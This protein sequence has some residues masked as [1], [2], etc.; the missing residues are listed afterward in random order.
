MVQEPGSLNA[1]EKQF[2]PRRAHE[3]SRKGCAR[4][5]QQRKKCDEVKPRCTRCAVRNY[6]CQYLHSPLESKAAEERKTFTPASSPDIPSSNVPSLAAPRPTSSMASPNSVPSAS[7]ASYLGSPSPYPNLSDDE[8]WQSNSGSSGILDSTDLALLSHY[9][10]HTSHAVSFDEDDLYALK[11]GIPNLAFNSKPLMASILALAAVSK[12]YDI[13]KHSHAP[14]KRLG[15]IIH[16]LAL[17]EGHHRASLRQIQAAIRTTDRYDH[18]LANGT[19]MV[20]YGSACHCVRIHLID[21]ARSRDES[22]PIEMLPAQ[23][24]WISLIRAVHTA[25]VGLLNSPSDY[26]NTNSVTDSDSWRW[27]SSSPPLLDTL[28]LSENETIS[29]ENGPSEQTGQLF[30]PIVGASYSPALEK[31]HAKAQ[32]I[33]MSESSRDTLADPHDCPQLPN[34]CSSEIQACLAAL[35]ILDNLISTMFSGQWTAP[36]PHERSIFNLEFPPVGPLSEV[37]PWLRSYLARVTSVTSSNAPLRRIIMAFVNQVPLEYLTLVQSI[38]DLIPIEKADTAWEK[39]DGESLPP[40]HPTH[41]L[42]MDIFAHWLV[43]VMLLDGVWWIGG[44]GEWELGR[45]VSFMRHQ[46]YLDPLASRGGKWWP[47]SMLKV[48]MELG[49]QIT[50]G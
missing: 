15:E 7:S 20:L 34:G 1:E 10:T 18:I 17:A 23:F 25:F 22:L 31:L 47:E 24:Q 50:A 14:H 39:P 29:A 11:V 46:T 4:C 42:A 43:L 30:L 9:L 2:K 35:E 8:G 37:S 5:K 6:R 12:C 32:F 27:R 38:L 45:V 49:G 3:K 36:E 41:L 26:S 44:I 21:I 16:L 13:I 33:A 28:T 19:I 48:K 40:H